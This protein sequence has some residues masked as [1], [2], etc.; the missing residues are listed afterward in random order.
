MDFA[1][2]PHRFGDRDLIADL[3]TA[4]D[5]LEPGA[6]G[7]RVW[8]VS[9]RVLARRGQGGVMFIDLEDVSG[10]VQLLVELDRLGE[11]QIGRAHV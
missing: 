11:E 10:R 6:E 4:E 2:L 9:G 5:G 1:S 3:R 8:R 7:A